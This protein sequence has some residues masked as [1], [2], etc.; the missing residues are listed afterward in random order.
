MERRR[1]RAGLL[2]AVGS[3]ALIGLVLSSS[4]GQF[5][6]T[7]QQTPEEDVFFYFA[8][9]M[10]EPVLCERIRWSV[11]QRYSELFAG[12]GASYAR[13]DC[14]ERAAQT[15]GD[16]RLCSRVR[17][18]VDVGFPSPG[19]SALGCWRRT[20]RHEHSFT[21]LDDALLVRTFER[22]GYDIDSLP[23]RGVYRS[24]VLLRDVYLALER[25]ATA[26]DRAR[27]LLGS[28][29]SALAN[30]SIV[31]DDRNY[32]VD[33]VAIAQSDPD[34]CEALPAGSTEPSRT[35]AFR[36]WCLYKLAQNYGSSR[37]C[38]RMRPAAEDPR[39]IDALAHG[40]Q[41]RIAEQLS[42]R[43][44]CE[45][46]DRNRTISSTAPHY[47]PEQPSDPAQT[48]RL[49]ALLSVPMPL[50]RGW[51]QDQ[52]ARYLN[53]FLSALTQPPGS[54]AD[55]DPDPAARVAARQDLLARLQHLA[56]DFLN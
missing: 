37:L 24:P 38:A 34:W 11:Y 32:L 35:H 10:G 19:Y 42:L 52:Q 17:P 54:L 23:T 13:S 49:L 16:A 53:E 56:D 18:L 15:R 36:E 50:A 9:Q 14:F 1:H 7:A 6:H 39:T 45:R 41:A 8:Q 4:P 27:Q 33:L 51:P 47:G 43:A 46:I 22:M 2:V 26:V 30:G 29:K 12:G 40:V 28:P 3:L 25:N 31:A 44:D 48:R 55:S 21:A 5:E 20:R